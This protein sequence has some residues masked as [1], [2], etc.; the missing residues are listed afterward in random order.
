ML[1]EIGRFVTRSLLPVTD[2]ASKGDGE[3]VPDQSVAEHRRW[4]D[5]ERRALEIQVLDSLTT[6]PSVSP[7]SNRRHGV[8]THCTLLDRTMFA[9]QTATL[10][11]R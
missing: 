6:Y 3:L 1:A 9:P 8:F 5:V 2:L 10:A 4:V 11:S 7:A